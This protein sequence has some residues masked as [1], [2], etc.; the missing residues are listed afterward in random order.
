MN[1][2]AALLGR[3]ARGLPPPAP[4]DFDAL[5]LPRSPNACLAAPAGDPRAH[6]A[7]PAYAAAPEALFAALLAAGDAQPRTARLAAWPERRQ[8]QWVERSPLCNF[9]DVIAA[10]VRAGPRGAELFL[11]SRSLL[12]WSDLGVNRRRVARWLSALSARLPAAEARPDPLAA[13]LA[14]RATGRH[15]LVMGERGEA[16]PALVL[17][18]AAAGA[19]SVRALSPERPADADARLRE[20]AHRAGLGALA[21]ALLE[22]GRVGSANAPP[23]PHAAS[24]A[25]ALWWLRE[26]P[27]AED[28]PARLGEVD[29]VVDPFGLET[30][31][32]PARR[33]AALRSVGARH[34]L[35]RTAALP[36][37]CCPGFAAQTL[38]HAGTLDAVRA[39]SLGAALGGLGVA[40][41]QFA[42][43]P[44]RLTPEAAAAAGLEAPWW[45][46]MGEA[47]LLGLLADAGFAG[48][49]LAREGAFVVVA[50]RA[51]A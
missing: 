31:A 28:L 27:E 34:L 45:W 1:P 32:E 48:E 37:D 3:G 2:L 19:A 30:L 6:L 40:L 5:R 12:G 11:Y 33:L 41:P 21:E 15:V 29:L 22:A 13:A 38:W 16:V 46:F 23:A 14:E 35:L 24:E 18:A 10:E 49:M 43:V 7:T 50:A 17:A 9:P 47:A 39:A 42:A 4:V 25:P 26:D 8:A 51:G 44:G 36:E 20:A